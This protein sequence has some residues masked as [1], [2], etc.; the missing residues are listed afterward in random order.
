M[1]NVFSFTGACGKDAEVRYSASGSAV[2]SVNVA[3]N[4]G[5]G[6]SQQTMWI[7]CA[8]WGKRAESQ[9][10]N[11]L[12]KGQQVFVSGELSQ[13]E[14]KANDGA[15][16]TSLSLN[17]NVMDLVGKKQDTPAASYPVQDSHN[18]TKSNAFQK[19][20]HNPDNFSDAEFEH[21]PF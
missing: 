19:Q 13:N 18:Q 10:V 4:V 16:K 12:K 3:C 7:Q 2:L 6:Q 11:Y 9:L 17:C 20:Q 1:S 14:Y 15:T 21:I 5:F 8:V